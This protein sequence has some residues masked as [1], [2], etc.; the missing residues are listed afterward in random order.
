[1]GD[2]MSDDAIA[3]LL[4]KE[5]KDASIKYS[6]MGMSAFTSTKQ[7]V[8]KPKPNT[9]FL[10]NLV[11]ETDSHNAALLAKE[12]SDSKARLEKLTG[13]KLQP[14]RDIRAR[15]LGAISAV[16][17][18]NAT[19]RPRTEDR[20][21]TTDKR[22]RVAERST[23][24]KSTDKHSRPSRG[25]KDSPDYERRRE[26]S[27]D[28]DYE[29]SKHSSR[30]SREDDDDLVRSRRHQSDHGR[31]SPPRDEHKSRSRRHP[32]RSPSR[33]RSRS[34]RRSKHKD[35]RRRSRSPRESRRRHYDEKEKPRSSRRERS[36]RE[37]NRRRADDNEKPKSNGHAASNKKAAKTDD[38]DPLEEIIGPL[39]P[40]KVQARGRGAASAAS[41]I[42][43]RFSETYDP[44]LD[45]SAGDKESGDDWDMVLDRVKWR[46][47]GAERLRAAGF[48]DK[49]ISLWETGKKE[50]VKYS[51]SGETREWDRGKLMDDMP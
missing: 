24:T 49:E 39:P 17:S 18:G 5:A 41:G 35:S 10:R 51:K 43:S 28:R 29:R 6:A 33:S 40:P 9:R 25:D 21:R 1:M 46:Q 30:R 27:R 26:R 11:K 8:N 45:L 50:E 47:Q 23:E 37:S 4:A 7:P 22:S 32:S 44:K 12:A 38:S 19:K 36:P 13:K 34:P 2:E 48:T 42:D 16:L 31:L 20:L 3:A 15:Q 14:E